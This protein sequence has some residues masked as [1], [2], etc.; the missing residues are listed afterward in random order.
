MPGS[1]SSVISQSNQV[2]VVVDYL[3]LNIHDMQYVTDFYVLQPDEYSDLSGVTISLHWNSPVTTQ[4][5]THVMKAIL[6][7]MTLKW[8][9]LNI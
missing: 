8:T 6:D 2:F 9:T 4:T 1:D 5:K 7:G 3:I